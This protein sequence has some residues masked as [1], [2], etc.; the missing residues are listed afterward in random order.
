MANTVTRNG[1]IIA[2]SA[3]DSDWDWLDTL[4]GTSYASGVNLMSIQ[5]QP[6]AADDIL[7]VRNAS[8]TGAPIVAWKCADEYDYK[9]YYCHGTKYKPYI[10]F[11][12]CTLTAG[13][14]V[15]ITQWTKPDGV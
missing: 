11:S 7:I 2:L 12:E 6:G 1:P 8:L 4:T 9:V 15:I 3:M 14:Q 10:D 5:F 13:H